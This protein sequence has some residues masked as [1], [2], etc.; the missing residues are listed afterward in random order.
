VSAAPA[1][2]NA[3]RVK[4]LPAA[5]DSPNHERNSVLPRVRAAMRYRIQR[6][7]ASRR[8]IYL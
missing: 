7:L 4:S 6:D 8:I 2:I 5:T 1:Q 3:D